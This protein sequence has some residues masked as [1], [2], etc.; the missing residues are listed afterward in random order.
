MLTTSVY[1]AARISKPEAC[2]PA[3]GGTPRTTDEG[4]EA[5]AAHRLFSGLSTHFLGA[6]PVCSPGLAA[7]YTDQHTGF[8]STGPG[9]DP[10]G[11]QCAWGTPCLMGCPWSTCFV[12]TEASSPIAG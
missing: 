2:M 1:M 5:V 4:Y 6:Y 3:L 10:P 7:A 9:A 12:P 8:R 11:L